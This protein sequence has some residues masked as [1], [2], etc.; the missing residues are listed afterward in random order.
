MITG[1]Y[2]QVFPTGE[3]ILKGRS[4][5]TDLCYRW[6]WMDRAYGNYYFREHV[7]HNINS[8]W[9]NPTNI[10]DEK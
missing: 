7:A 3:C 6:V 9:G 8:F 5:E 4:H 1:T 2:I 10:K